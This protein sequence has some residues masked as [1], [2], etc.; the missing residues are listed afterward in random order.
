[1]GDL[2][3]DITGHKIELGEYVLY[4]RV[5]PYQ[6][7]AILIRCRVI[8]LLSNGK[9]RLKQEESDYSLIPSRFLSHGI[10]TS[11]IPSM[12]ISK[13]SNR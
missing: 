5:N 6:K 13:L 7:N 8:K 1:M 3:R 12:Q 10:F 4:S 2:Y 9:I 11:T